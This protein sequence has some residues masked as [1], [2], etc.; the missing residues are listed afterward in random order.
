MSVQLILYPQYYNGLTPLSGAASEF[1][2]DGINFVSVNTASTTTSV[3]GTLPAAFVSANTFTPNTWYRFSDSGTS[4]TQTSNQIGGVSGNGILQQLSNLISGSTYQQTITF[5]AQSNSDTIA[6]LLSGASIMNTISVSQ[7]INSPTIGD[8]QNGQVICDL[9]EDEDIPLT[10]SIDEFKNAAEKVQSYSK[11]FKL[12]ATKRNNQ[13][14]DN[15]FEVTRTVNGAGYT[16]NPYVKT[17]CELKQDGLI[18]FEGYFR[19]INIIE[20]GGEI[21]YNVNLY[22]EVI[23]LA[24]LL[25]DRTFNL[26]DFTELTHPYNRTQIQNSWSLSTG[27]T[28]S[29]AATSGFRS[30]KTIAYP[31]VDW[32]HSAT[33]AD[34][35]GTPNINMPEY[36]DL[37]DVFR[38]FIQVKYLI[39]RIFNQPNFPF[40]Y[41]SEFF[42]TT[43]F[44][45]LYMDFNWGS[46]TI[47]QSVN[48]TTSVWSYYFFGLGDPSGTIYLGTSFAPYQLSFNMPLF[49]SPALP[50]YALATTNTI[51]STVAGET[52]N[53]NYGY[54]VKNTDSSARTVNFQW[55]LT[56]GT[57]AIT[58]F[59]QSGTISIPAGGTYTYTGTLNGVILPTIGDTLKMEC[60]AEVVSKI[61][62][63]QLTFPNGS[64]AYLTASV[65][66]SSVTNNTMLQNLRGETGQWEFLKGIMTMFNLV[67]IPDK[68]NPSNILIEPYVDVFIN[69]T[70]DPSS[71]TL[72]ARGIAHDWTD[73]ID[74]EELTLE[75]L[76]ELNRKTVFRFEED[77]DQAFKSYK[78]ASGGFLYGSKIWD[79]SEA[80]AS[81]ETLLAGEEEIVASPFAATVIAPLMPQFPDLIVPSVYSY[82]ADEGT[83]TGFDNLPRIMYRADND[84]GTA[85]T[86]GIQTLSSSTYFLPSFAGVASANMTTYLQ[87]SH[88]SGVPASSS[89]S[90]DYHFGECGLI[91]PAGY[92]PQQNLFN[93]Y[94][95]PYMGEL[96]NSD[97]RIFKA[98]VNLHAGDISTF[99]L[100]D[101]VFIKNRQ[102]RVNN[103]LYKP[104]DL[105]VVEFILIP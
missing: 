61:Q 1:I 62:Q 78:Q 96:Y 94:W 15:I 14:F 31:F 98:K 40:S 35:S 58:T 30:E 104:N 22:S 67:S 11:A 69:N 44:G 101:T 80:G 33:I 74:Q 4:L 26:L 19:L 17:K 47:P 20:K 89:A 97:T 88:L 76:T 71:L 100:F 28:Y 12:P 102:Y 43:E 37:S 54:T 32:N 55:K 84:T 79:A 91:Q 90:Y 38:P 103:I 53:L 29:S 13:I 68:S 95:R 18:L 75:P 39:D 63:H 27:V 23:A 52:Y 93:L 105:A 9:Y 57:G 48:F 10:L 49:G 46:E 36:A 77:D 92:P 85:D 21:S 56:E 42:S 65:G 99:N 70:N 25:G 45:K 2:T 86:N 24:D 7:L 60:K 8:V 50:N 72:A 34:G 59:N 73:K 5:T 3:S 87:F 64:G 41:T 81:L 82:D 66:V 83:S 51:T 16:F 6:I